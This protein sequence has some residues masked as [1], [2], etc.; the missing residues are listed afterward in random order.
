GG[1][2]TAR[3]TTAWVAENIELYKG[4]NTIVIRAWDLAGN[5]SWR[6]IVVSLR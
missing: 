1:S 6:S 3:G 4:N 2:G 5:S